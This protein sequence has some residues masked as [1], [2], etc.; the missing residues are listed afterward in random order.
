MKALQKDFCSLC[1]E[2]C[3]VMGH[4]MEERLRVRNLR[5][6]DSAFG[7]VVVHEKNVSFLWIAGCVVSPRKTGAGA[8]YSQWVYGP[9]Q[10]KE[11][12]REREAGLYI[13]ENTNLLRA[14]LISYNAQLR[15]FSNTDLYFK[16]DKK[17]GGMIKVQYSVQTLNVE[18]YESA[19]DIPRAVFEVLGARLRLHAICPFRRHI[20]LELK[21]EEAAEASSP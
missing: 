9:W 2:G 3:H 12:N 16:F 18:M 8:G 6:G 17:Y 13:D 15:Y 4:T 21:L 7:R 20:G 1:P 10:V 14:Q 19:A 5:R 11:T